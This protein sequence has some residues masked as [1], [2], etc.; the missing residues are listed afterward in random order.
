MRKT[1]SLFDHYCTFINANGIGYTYSSGELN[2]NV[3][4]HEQPTRWKSWS[5]NRYYRT[6]CYQ[7]MLGKTGFV[8][9]LSR[10]NWE[11]TRT[12]PEWFTLAHLQVLA[13]YENPNSNLSKEQILDMLNT[14]VI[15]NSLQEP[16][17]NNH[18]S[19][20]GSAYNATYN[21]FYGSHPYLAVQKDP[22]Y[23][24]SGAYVNPV[25]KSSSV[26]KSYFYHPNPSIFAPA[27]VEKITR[28][29][30]EFFKSQDSVKERDQLLENLRENIGLLEAATLIFDKVQ[31][32][33]PL[34]QGRVVNIF[35]QLKALTETVG[36]RIEYNRTK[37]II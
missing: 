19:S 10:G 24:A 36:S 22:L 20:L 27:K 34:V 35:E 3:G 18:P 7:S 31:I 5:R 28:E 8:K 32:L 15:E 29:E 1:D 26:K 17:N 12:V 14:T 37:Q 16:K 13:G 11:I 25:D 21:A 2:A 23:Y 33:D 9:K 30:S 6:R 4:I